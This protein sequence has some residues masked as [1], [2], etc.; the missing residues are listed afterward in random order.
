MDWCRLPVDL[1]LREKLWLVKFHAPLVNGSR[2][3][4]SVKERTESI[5]THDG[6]DRV[7]V[8]VGIFARI[9]LHRLDDYANNLL[10]R[11]AGS[12]RHALSWRYAI[13]L[14][15]RVHHVLQQTANVGFCNRDTTV[16]DK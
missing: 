10:Y 1:F 2:T 15:Q 16:V 5:V 8:A 9:L 7:N 3:I 14:F 12:F 6:T 4:A 11:C 13:C